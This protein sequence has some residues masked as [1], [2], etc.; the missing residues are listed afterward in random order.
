MSLDLESQLSLKF[1]D[2]VYSLMN[3]VTQQLVY[4]CRIFSMSHEDCR[5]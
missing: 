5:E 3:E 4:V 2:I 1:L